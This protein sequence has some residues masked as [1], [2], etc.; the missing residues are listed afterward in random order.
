MKYLRKDYVPRTQ[1]IRKINGQMSTKTSKPEVLADHL[2]TKVWNHST[3]PSLPETPLF[4]IAQIDAGPFTEQRLKT[5]KARPDQVPAEI[6]KYV[7]REVHKAL[8]SP[9]Q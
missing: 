3:L 5:R 2:E 9:L 6:W 4:P 1:G 7:P 8:F